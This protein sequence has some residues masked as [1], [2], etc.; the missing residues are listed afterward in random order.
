MQLL[1]ERLLDPDGAESEESS[2][3]CLGVLPLETVMRQ[4]KTLRRTV[5]RTADGETVSGYEIH[6][7]ET[8][9]L[10]ESPPLRTIRTADG[11]VVGYETDN[12]FATYLHGVFD[13]DGFRRRFLDGLRRRRNWGPRGVITPYGLE[14]ALNRLADHVRSRVDIPAIYRRMGL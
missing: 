10:T 7:G 8:R 5:A 12:V 9:A 1:G 13:E 6:H 3:E 4:E 2:C 14:T 11:R